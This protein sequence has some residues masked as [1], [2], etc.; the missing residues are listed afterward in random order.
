M[1]HTTLLL[2]CNIGNCE[3]N[4]KEAYS[5]VC[6]R[7]GRVVKSSSV[8]RSEAWGFTSNDYFLNQIVVCET[9][10]SP[11]E[12]LFTLWEIEKLFG[13]ER[14]SVADEL[15]KYEA[16]KRG[17]IGYSSRAMDIDIIFYGDKKVET[18][19]LTIPHPLYEE[20]EFVLELL[21]ELNYGFINPKNKT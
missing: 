6:E 9:S 21:Q 19:L 3:E 4:M 2:G 14:G 16:R 15:K 13:R 18:P 5:L 17:E 8:K 10:L 11:E 1:I 20:R 7:V 12:L